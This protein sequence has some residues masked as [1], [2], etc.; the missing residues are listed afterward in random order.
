[1]DKKALFA[2]W[3]IDEF[4]ISDGI[5]IAGS[6]NRSLERVVLKCGSGEMFIA[7]GFSAGKKSKQIKQNA[8]LE[9][10]RK[11]NLEGIYPFL[12]SCDGGHG[13]E[14]NGLFWQLRPYLPMDELPRETLGEMEEFGTLW[15]KF[16]LDFKKASSSYNFSNLP[17]ERFFFSS[18]IPLLR[19]LMIHQMP[20]ILSKFDALVRKISPFFEIEHTLP[21]QISHGDF[22]PGNILVSAGKIS[23]VIDWEFCG[24]KCAGYDPALLLGC[25]G[26]DDPDWLGGKAAEIFRQLLFEAGFMPRISW[27]HFTSLMAAIRF[28]W[29]GEW[30]DMRDRELAERELEYIEM[31]SDF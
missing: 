23:A 22:H 14:R 19:A 26:M 9:H 7:E 11:E 8:F 5:V 29:L 6:P 10:L 16:L 20:Q 2:H 3:G 15:G 30:V 18:Y 1:M 17:N 13:V 24:L 27:E 21:C 25:L 31:L 4:E 12:R 28:G